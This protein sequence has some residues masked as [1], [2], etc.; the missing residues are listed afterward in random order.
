MWISH[1]VIPMHSWPTSR[2]VATP[3]WHLELTSWGYTMPCRHNPTPRPMCA[4]ESHVCGV[5]VVVMALVL[6]NVGVGAGDECWAYSVSKFK[7]ISESN[8]FDTFPNLVRHFWVNATKLTIIETANNNN[9]IPTYTNCKCPHQIRTVR[10][11]D[12]FGDFEWMFADWG[13]SPGTTTVLA[14]STTIGTGDIIQMRKFLPRET[15]T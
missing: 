5:N 15:V 10:T 9:N 2:L 4:P 8:S 13:C 1:Q 7:V 14:G 6:M 11:S 3:P 12:G